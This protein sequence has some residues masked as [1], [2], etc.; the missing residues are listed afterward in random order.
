MK[1]EVIFYLS[2]SGINVN[3]FKGEQEQQN[4]VICKKSIGIIPNQ[5]VTLVQLNKY[6]VPETPI[7]T[8]VNRDRRR[9]IKTP[10]SN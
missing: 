5:V 8:T 7:F 4:Y 6:K 10:V 9:P 1:C 3:E 2:K